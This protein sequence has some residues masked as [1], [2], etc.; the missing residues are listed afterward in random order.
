MR[1]NEVVNYVKSRNKSLPEYKFGSL[2]VIVKDPLPDNINL[3]NVF[4]EITSILPPRFVSLVDVVYVGNFDF[5]EEREINSLYMDGAIYVSNEQDNNEDMKDDIVHEISHAVEERYKDIA[6]EDEEIKNEYFG[7]LKK[8]KN[9]LSF[10]GYDI[11]GIE[12]FNEQYNKDFDKFLHEVVGYEAL[13]SFINGLF[14]APYSVTSLREYFGRGFEE[15]FLGN[16]DYLRTV[17]PY[18][19]KKINFLSS[20]SIREIKNEY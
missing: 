16:R 13:S 14:L 4:K 9:Y 20:A 1:K 11:R 15:Y 8:L 19:F 2:Q 6:Y 7:K 3:D 10:E 12:F 5:F 17:C 18:L